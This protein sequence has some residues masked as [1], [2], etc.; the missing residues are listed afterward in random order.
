V[1]VFIGHALAVNIEFAKDLSVDKARKALEKM[2]GV[3]VIDRPDVG[4]FITPVE[5]V[6]ED[7]IAVSRLRKDPT[8]PH[9]INLW[10]VADN[11]RKGAA[12]NAVQIAE[13]IIAQKGKKYHKK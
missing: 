2:P 1:P 12:L 11:L 3:W 10:I 8:V 13:S 6:G 4:A 5:I 7:N 9:G